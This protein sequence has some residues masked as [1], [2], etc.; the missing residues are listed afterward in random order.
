MSEVVDP[1]LVAVCSIR[2]LMVT[3]RFKQ[4]ATWSSGLLPRVKDV[5]AGFAYRMVDTFMCPQGLHR[6]RPSLCT[7][8]FPAI[9]RPC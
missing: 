7:W 1:E 2:T 9:A 4:R 5:G 8:P 3:Q 6:G